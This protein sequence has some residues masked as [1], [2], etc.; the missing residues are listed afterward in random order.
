[1]STRS[2]KSMSGIRPTVAIMGAG[3]GG[4]ATAMLLAKAG[5]S[6][7]VYER[8]DH[9]GGRSASIWADTEAGWFR[10]D[11]GP[12]FFLYPRV[13]A[14]IFETCGYRLDEEIKL[15]RIDPLYRLIF[16]D[17]GSLLNIWANASALTAEIARLCP[18]DAAAL[19]QFMAENRRKL[20]AFRPVLE[21]PFVGLRSYLSPSV[22]KALSL[23]RPLRSV[24]RD[25]QRFFT[26]PRLRLAFS[27]QSKY[28]GMSPFRCP[29]LF[30]ILS[31]L[32]HEYGVWHPQGGCGEVMNRMAAIAKELGATIRLAEPVEEIVFEGRRAVGIRNA[33]GVQHIDALV[34]NA[35]FAQ[36]MRR[37]VP[38][39]L[40]SRWSNRTIARKKFSC[41][42]FM[43]YLGVD[44]KVDELPHHSVYLADD[45][46][47]N[48]AEIDAGVT[49]PTELSLYVQN[50]CITD[51]TLAPAGHST[52]YVL[53]PVAHRRENGIDWNGAQAGRLRQ[54]TLT[55]LARLGI[56][57]LEQRIRFEK[58][59]TPLGWE[60]DLQVFRGATFNLT[61]SLDQMLHLRPHNRFEDLEGVYLVGGG[62]HPGSGLPVIFESAR[63]TTRLMAQDFGLG[64]AAVR[65]TA[66]TWQEVVA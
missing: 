38:N 32:E 16:G 49:V 17:S 40:R 23:L 33:R 10:F 3:P 6:V 35:D 14:E 39:R 52:L 56:P 59:M 1:M 2:S 51:P 43:L 7:T 20:D 34:I 24:D 45:Y 30:T 61:H 31:F 64:R 4:L 63:I 55:T 44:G 13:L 57:D 41:S 42:T 53:V 19:P 47:R 15:T 29:S 9:V 46:Q 60:Q 62:T 18:I 5:M 37:F 65:Q 21:S 66:P 58:V 22:I 28:L 11:R 50:A 12:T 26:D 36:A 54:K 8:L 48:I 25:L 27:F